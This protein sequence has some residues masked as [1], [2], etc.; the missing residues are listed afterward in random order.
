MNAI[1]REGHVPSSLAPAR[2]APWED[3]TSLEDQ[4]AG[5]CQDGA[6]GFGDVL[7]GERAHVAAGAG[8]CHVAGVHAQIDGIARAHGDVDRE[9]PRVQ[10]GSK[11]QVEAP[12]GNERRRKDGRRNFAPMKRRKPGSV[13][14]KVCYVIHERN[15]L[16]DNCHQTHLDGIRSI[17]KA[18]IQFQI[19]ARRRRRPW[20]NQVNV[21]R[22]GPRRG[23][24]EENKGEGKPAQQGGDLLG[25][26]TTPDSA[27]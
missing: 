22:L 18:E 5:E 4:T 7:H 6:A 9:K 23:Y 8:D 21:L 15:D 1:R 2:Q 14:A 19:I 24:S 12:S 10:F 27:D 20:R 11:V 26:T 16:R 13:S 17:S 3:Q 25:T